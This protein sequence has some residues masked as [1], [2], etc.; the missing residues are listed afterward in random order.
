[1]RTIMKVGI[2]FAI[3]A[4]F[5]LYKGYSSM[6]NEILSNSK[7]LSK[8]LTIMEELNSKG[9]FEVIK[10]HVPKH[11]FDNFLD[12]VVFKEVAKSSTNLSESQMSDSFARIAFHE[13]TVLPNHLDCAEPLILSVIAVCKVHIHLNKDMYKS[14]FEGEDPALKGDSLLRMA[15]VNDKKLN[16]LVNDPESKLANSMSKDNFIFVETL[17]NARQIEHEIAISQTSDFKK[18]LIELHQYYCNPEANKHLV[19]QIYSSEAHD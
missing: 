16:E 18:D 14:L 9:L 11:D 7:D 8:I 1:M 13:A 6:K 17:N 2:G 5:V 3:G 15:Q 10:Q 12:N 4:S 19:E